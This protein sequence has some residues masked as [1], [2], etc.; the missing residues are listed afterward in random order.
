MLY[1]SLLGKYQI[2]KYTVIDSLDGIQDHREHNLI[3]LA[4]Y[5]FNKAGLGSFRISSSGSINGREIISLL[6][7][8]KIKDIR[9]P[10]LGYIARY[11][12]LVLAMLL[13][14]PE[15][16]KQCSIDSF[17][18][19]GYILPVAK[20]IELLS[21]ISIPSIVR[22]DNDDY[23]VFYCPNSV[24]DIDRSPVRPVNKAEEY[25]DPLKIDTYHDRAT[26][27]PDGRKRNKIR[28]KRDHY[29]GV[30]RLEFD[31]IG[32]QYSYFATKR[33]KEEETLIQVLFN[34]K[35]TLKDIGSVFL[36]T[37]NNATGS[38]IRVCLGKL[39]CSKD[40]LQIKFSNDLRSLNKLNALHCAY[41]LNMIGI[42]LAGIKANLAYT[43]RMI[44][45]NSGFVIPD[46]WSKVG[47][48]VNYNQENRSFR[49]LSLGISSTRKNDPVILPSGRDKNTYPIGWD[50]NNR[51][52]ATR[53]KEVIE[54]PLY[55][56]ASERKKT[57]VAIEKSSDLLL[58]KEDGRD[59]YFGVSVI[60]PW[61]IIRSDNL[62]YPIEI[63][64]LKEVLHYTLGYRT[65]KLPCEFLSKDKFF[66]KIQQ[67]RDKLT[68]ELKRLKRID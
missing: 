62:G 36:Q 20:D 30:E 53:P 35:P 10:R 14:K 5:R 26:L 47:I 28:I 58:V 3:D 44:D 63:F 56:S 65:V 66:H 52:F 27:N 37:N 32:D 46:H 22:S 57:K 25:Y 61:F 51:N 40:R 2:S 24:K 18:D 42:H 13:L 39:S 17:N 33:D 68:E 34:I 31:R 9:D 55:V 23:P 60:D 45:P 67:L 1:S 16:I 15:V 12:S 43:L 64:D 49:I 8:L 7:Q 19:F 38:K 54:T 29:V 11:P 6:S 21:Y 48:Q 59:R 4:L 41:L 50:P